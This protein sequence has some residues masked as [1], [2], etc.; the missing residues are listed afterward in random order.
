MNKQKLQQ[1]IKQ[2]EGEVLEIYEDSL[3]YKTLGVGHLITEADDEFGQ[4]VGTSIDQDIVDGYFDADFYKHVDETIKVFGSQEDFHDLPEPIQHVLVDMC[5]NLGAPRL[6]KFK[7]MLSAC[8]EH[9]W[10]QMAIQMEDSRWYNQVGVRSR[11]LQTMV[12]NVPKS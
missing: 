4:A 8:R 1:Q 2:L 12:L 7:N 10:T 5:F 6:A 3:G 11:N 9:D